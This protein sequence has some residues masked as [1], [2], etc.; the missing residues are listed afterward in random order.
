LKFASAF[1]NVISG[2]N[3]SRLIDRDDHAPAEIEEYKASGVKVLS[4]RTIESYLYDDEVLTLLYEEHGKANNVADLL[5]KKEEFL[6][7]SVNRNNPIDDIKSAASE[8]YSF[9]KT[10]LALTGCGN[11][12]A[13]FARHMLVPLVAPGTKVYDALK[14][15]VFGA[16]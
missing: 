8:L 11:D 16:D 15:D 2:M 13:S 9:I 6:Q 10:E 12:Q 4:K 7:A 14:A 3:V 1:P 5:A